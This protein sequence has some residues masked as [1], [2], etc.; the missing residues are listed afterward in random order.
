VKPIYTLSPLFPHQNPLP[1]SAIAAALC[2]VA[3]ESFPTTPDHPDPS[4]RSALSH[5]CS[6]PAHPSPPATHAVGIGRPSRSLPPAMGQG[7]NF[8]KLF[9]PGSLLQKLLY[10]F[11][12]FCSE[13][14][15]ILEKSEKC[16]TNFVVFLLIS[17][18][19]SCDEFEKFSCIVN[20]KNIS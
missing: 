6:L 20:S 5:S 12:F 13:L 18:I 16:E 17:S 19:I 11:Y 2:F 9:F 4:T 14:Q 7:P 1:T 3:D 8:F 15:K 10:P